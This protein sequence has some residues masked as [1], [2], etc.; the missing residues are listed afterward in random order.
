MRRS[1]YTFIGPLVCG[2]LAASARYGW[3]YGFG[4]AGVG[5][6]VGLAVYLLGKTRYLGALGAPRR[7]VTTPAR[8]ARPIADWGN[9]SRRSCE[10]V[11]C[12]AAGTGRILSAVRRPV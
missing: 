3:R 11:P 4:A 9:I 10:I 5:M 6:E 7:G 2:Y 12:V 8:D 1:R